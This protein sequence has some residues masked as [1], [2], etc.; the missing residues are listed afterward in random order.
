MTWAAIVNDRKKTVEQVSES[1][2][3]LLD[4]SDLEG[5]GLLGTDNGSRAKQGSDSSVN[6]GL[7]LAFIAGM[8]YSFQFVPFQIHNAQHKVS[9]QR[10][11]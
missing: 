1:E 3:S 9:A 5:S 8:L 6:K 7:L 10:E 4:V 2:E 11:W